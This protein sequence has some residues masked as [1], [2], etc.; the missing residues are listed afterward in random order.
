MVPVVPVLVLVLLPVLLLVL[1]LLVLVLVLAVPVLSRKNRLSTILVLLLVL[2]LLLLLLL[3]LHNDTTANPVPTLPAVFSGSEALYPLFL[4]SFEQKKVGRCVLGGVAFCQNQP[5]LMHD[6]ALFLVAQIPPPCLHRRRSV[7]A[8]PTHLPSPSAAQR[9][10]GRGNAAISGNSNGMDWGGTRNHHHH[11][12][13]VQT[14]NG[15][16]A[17]SADGNR[18]TGFA[19][20]VSE[21]QREACLLS[22]FST[23]PDP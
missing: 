6:T 20:V 3:L 19:W 14:R 10:G 12:P 8:V 9:S 2:L 18:I 13:S 23:A 5:G 1:V 4:Y 7:P 22:L 16:K 21:G 11:R 15:H 17:N